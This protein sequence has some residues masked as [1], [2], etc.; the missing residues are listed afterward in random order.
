MSNRFLPLVCAALLAGC[1]SDE[2]VW[3]VHHA[4]FIPTETGLS[5]TQ[6]WEFF[7][8][9]WAESGAPDA[10]VCARAQLVTGALVA[11][12]PGCDGCV[13]AYDLTVAELESDCTDDLATN[14]SF[15][16]PPTIGIG[17]VPGDLDALDPYPGRSVG[18]YLST[19]GRELSAYGYGYEETLDWNGEVGAPGWRIDQTYTL[20]PAFAWDLRK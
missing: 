4:S 16:T 13:A 20:W 7:S 6:T 5:G 14:A 1:A 17:D 3:A 8:E 11:A 10:F 19:D 2:P 12:L 15:V 18:W 9:A